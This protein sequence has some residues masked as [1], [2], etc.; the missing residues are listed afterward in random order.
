MLHAREAELH[1]RAANHHAEAAALQRVHAD[2]LRGIS[3]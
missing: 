3:L 2:H 1:G